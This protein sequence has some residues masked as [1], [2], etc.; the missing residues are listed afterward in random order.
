MSSRYYILMWHDVVA[1]TIHNVIRK[2]DH[3]KINLE[4]LSATE[5][6]H[7]HQLKEF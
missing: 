5:Y 4:N 2:K 1:K 7:Q 3:P 6:I